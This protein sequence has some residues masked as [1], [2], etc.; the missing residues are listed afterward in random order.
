MLKTALVKVSLREPAGRLAEMLAALR[1]FGTEAVHLVYVRP[2]DG[3]ALPERRRA[4]LA[5]IREEADAASLAADVHVMAGHAPGCVLEAA[6]RLQADYIAIAWLHKAVL[7]QTLLGSIDGDIVRMSGAPVFI[8]KRRFLG[9]TESLDSVLYATDFQATDGR[10]MPYLRNKDFQART[11]YMLHVRERAPDPDT[12]DR[13]RQRVL[14]NLERLASEC[15][16]A[17]ENV[18]TLEALGPVRRTIVS[19][20]KATGVDLIIV[21]KVD[22]PD[23]VKKLTGSVADQLPHRSPCSVFIIPGYGPA[24]PS[25]RDAARAGS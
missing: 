8:F 18:E 12:D 3:R 21:G 15:A 19:T 14:A 1:S 16:H 22:D 4:K 10:V 9:R 25:A 11:L 20:A 2:P 5:R 23:V 6:S 17:Y 13:R 24:R 7:R